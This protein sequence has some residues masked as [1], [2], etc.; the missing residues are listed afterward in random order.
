M[1]VDLPDE[2]V[3]ARGEVFVLEAFVLDDDGLALGDQHVDP[4]V[5]HRH[6]D[7]ERALEQ[8]HVVEHPAAHEVG[9]DASRVPL[10][11]GSHAVEPHGRHAAPQTPPH[12][13][14]HRV[15]APCGGED[16]QH[17]ERDD[18]VVEELQ[19]QFR[20]ARRAVE[21]GAVVELLA[22]AHEEFLHHRVSA[23]AS[24]RCDLGDE[25]VAGLEVQAVD[26]LRGDIDAVAIAVEQVSESVGMDRQPAFLM[27]NAGATRRG[28]LGAAFRVEID[29]QQQYVGEID[30]QADR[31]GDQQVQYHIGVFRL[32]F[33]RRLFFVLPGRPLARHPFLFVLSRWSSGPLRLDPRVGSFPVPFRL[34]FFPPPSGFT[35]LRSVFSPS[36]LSYRIPGLPEWISF[37]SPPPGSRRARSS[38]GVGFP[39]PPRVREGRSG[40]G[41]HRGGIRATFRNSPPR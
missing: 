5:E 4:P 22:I 27:Q 34:L 28:L 12:V 26:T 21:E 13:E 9:Q 41:S 32:E 20:T 7:G 19:Q 38:S 17:D 35:G 16:R 33:H 11:D 2:H 24:R 3:V 25:P 14:R 39:C 36:S 10:R 15:V 37:F 8:Q 18:Q 40:P 30:H 31:H 23:R 1:G 6:H 29:E